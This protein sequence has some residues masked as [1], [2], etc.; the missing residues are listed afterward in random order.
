MSHRNH[1]NH[2]CR[3]ESFFLLDKNCQ[4]LPNNYN[5]H[6]SLGFVG[7]FIG[8]SSLAGNYGNYGNG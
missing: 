2:R 7:L 4:Q 5:E 1:R 6:G 3:P 8:N